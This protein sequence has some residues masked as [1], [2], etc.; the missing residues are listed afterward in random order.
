MGLNMESIIR[1]TAVSLAMIVAAVFVTSFAGAASAPSDVAKT[2]HNLAYGGGASITAKDASVTEVCVFCHTPHSAGQSS[3]LWNKFVGNRTFRLYTSSK[4]I[5][6]ATRHSTLPASSPSLLCLSCHDGKTAINVLHSTRYG[7]D[8]G[9]SYPAG[10]R[11]IP[12]NGDGGDGPKPI[13]NMGGTQD[14]LGDPGA[15]MISNTIASGDNADDLTKNH[16]IGFSYTLAVS[17]KT[18]NSLF[19]LPTVATKSGSKVRFFTTANRVE[20]SS[21]HDPHLYTQGTNDDD[22]KPFLV[23]TVNRSLLCLSCHNK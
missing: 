21:C 20:C 22:Q 5:T 18:D 9:G 12:F 4:T 7:T 14:L 8:A 17:Q 6:D 13:P 10:S 3:L 19:D 23:Q 16:P 15:L 11:V 1:K 2:K